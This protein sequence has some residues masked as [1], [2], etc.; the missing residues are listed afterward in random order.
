MRRLPLNSII[1]PSLLWL[2]GPAGHI[3]HPTLSNTAPLVRAIKWKRIPIVHC[4]WLVTLWCH[5]LLAAHTWTPCV[6]SGTV[7]VRWPDMLCNTGLVY[8]THV[9][10]AGLHSC[11]L[12]RCTPPAAHNTSVQHLVWCL[13]AQYG[14]LLAHNTPDGRQ[15]IASWWVN[16]RVRTS[17]F[18][19]VLRH[20]VVG[21][22][23]VMN[24]QVFILTQKM[25]SYFS[26]KV[27]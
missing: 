9:A 4:K 27:A 1:R 3:C 14:A 11:L 2:F 7:M 21:L 19:D 13:L 23:E 17:V 24:C 8:H 26:W 15:L 18:C 6:S 20:L 16:T 12:Y 10:P 25:R 22:N 5:L